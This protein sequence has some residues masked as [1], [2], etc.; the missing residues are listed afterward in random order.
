MQEDYSN[1]FIV[2][3]RDNKASRNSELQAYLIATFWRKLFCISQQ[4]RY[5]VTSVA[6]VEMTG[7]VKRTWRRWRRTTPSTW[8]A[9]K[10]T[11]TSTSLTGSSAPTPS[12]RASSKGSKSTV[13]LKYYLYLLFMKKINQTL[14]N[15]WNYKYIFGVFNII[16][17][18]IN[19]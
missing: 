10:T 15:R 1:Y 8:T 2:K 18:Q 11:P 9:A 12:R 19:S 16:R 5:I 4:V 3:N 17:F 14:F 13:C 6:T 7:R